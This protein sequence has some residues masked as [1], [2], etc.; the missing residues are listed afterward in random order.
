MRKAIS[1]HRQ[2]QSQNDKTSEFLGDVV[3]MDEPYWLN[4]RAYTSVNVDP[5]I[6]YAKTY[7]EAKRK[8]V[9]H[10][11]VKRVLR[12]ASFIQDR[13]YSKCFTEQGW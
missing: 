9:K 10:F 13:D 4:S 11:G 5:I 2:C 8:L 3:N 7:K 6:V 1:I 12:T